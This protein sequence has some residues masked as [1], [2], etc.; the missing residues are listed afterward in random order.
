MSNGERQKI[1]IGDLVVAENLAEV[2]AFVI[3]HGN[4]I[5][6]KF[7]VKHGGCMFQLLSNLINADGT[8]HRVVRQVQ[9]ANNAIFHQRTSRYLDGAF[10]DEGIGTCRVRVRI[11]ELCNPKIYV[12]QITHALDALL[13]HQFSNMLRCNDFISRRK[14][15]EAPDGGRRPYRC[16]SA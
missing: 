6:P 4:I 15:G 8:A 9:H 14:N 12:Q 11:V 16:V 13:F 10:L 7:V 5:R 1:G 2:D 3:E